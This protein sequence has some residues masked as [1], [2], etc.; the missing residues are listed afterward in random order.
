MGVVY[1]ARQLRLERVV[2]LKIVLYGA[3][4][5]TDRRMRF[6]AEADA[7]A[8]LQHPSIVQVYEFGEHE[9]V[10]FLAQRNQIAA[11]AHLSTAARTGYPIERDV[12][13]CQAPVCLINHQFCDIG[14]N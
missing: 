3:H 6:R 14:A 13:V 7:I 8:R 1:R 10:P 11:R 2:A 4:A 12:G 9:G 5:S